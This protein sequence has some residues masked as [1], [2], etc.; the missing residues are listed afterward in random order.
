MEM[1]R[2]RAVRSPDGART[3]GRHH[4]H[5][6]FGAVRTIQGVAG[7]P[8]APRHGASS[9]ARCRRVRPSRPFDRERASM[10]LT[11][12]IICPRASVDRR[13][14]ALAR[15]GLTERP[16]VAGTD[17]RHPQADQ[18][19]AVLIGILGDI[20][21]RESLAA[22]VRT[23][24][25]MPSMEASGRRLH[26]VADITPRRLTPSSPSKS[27]C[28]GREAHRS[29]WPLSDF[30]RLT[31]MIAQLESSWAPVPCETSAAPSFLAS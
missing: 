18:G 12:F 13:G 3:P 7:F 14:I 5:G 22:G 20:G 25:S 11:S 2:V 23:E 17:V 15:P 6:Q 21:R 30:H 19:N 24:G 10:P 26:P 27:T 4:R 8:R 31:S 1:I 9:A 16:H 28:R 29:R